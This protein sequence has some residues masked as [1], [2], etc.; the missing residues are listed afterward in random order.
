[1][2]LIRRRSRRKL[3]SDETQLAFVAKFLVEINVEVLNL[4]AGQI[5]LGDGA[6]V[7]FLDDALRL[8]K[9]S[10]FEQRADESAVAEIFFLGDALEDFAAMVGNVVGNFVAAPLGHQLE[11]IG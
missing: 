5:F 6:A 4:E 11:N 8:F 3:L 10:L 2:R 7:V 1:M 9:P